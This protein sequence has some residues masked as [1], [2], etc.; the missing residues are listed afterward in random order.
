MN[1]EVEKSDEESEKSRELACS[2]LTGLV[3]G[4]E[5]DFIRKTAVFQ[6]DKTLFISVLKDMEP[7]LRDA[8]VLSSGGRVLISGEKETAEA[9]KNSLTQKKLMLLLKEIQALRDNSES[10][11]NH[12][13]S[14]TRL[15][16]I[17]YSIK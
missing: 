15:S 14:L 13:L 11:A 5:L 12:N 17:L 16:S 6:K 8:L 7:L 10:S 4:N 3:R 1:E 2:L 9:L